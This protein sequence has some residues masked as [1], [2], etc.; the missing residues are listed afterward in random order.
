MYADKALY[1]LEI[2]RNCIKIHQNDEVQKP[3]KTHQKLTSKWYQNI[4]SS[5]QMFLDHCYAFILSL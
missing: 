3:S 4:N 5:S 1:R 2:Y